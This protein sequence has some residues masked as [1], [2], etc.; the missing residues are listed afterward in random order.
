[1]LYGHSLGNIQMQYYAANNWDADLKAVVLLGMF[2][3]LPWKSRHML[4]ANEDTFRLLSDAAFKALREGRERELLPLRMGRTGTEA[5]PVTG[6]HFLSYRSESSST[7]DGTYWIKRIPRPILMVRDA[8]DAVVAPF[9]PYMLL[10][11]A[12][13]A[14]SLVPSIKYVML[15]NSKGTSFA[16][17]SFADNQLPLV[18]TITAWLA[19]QHL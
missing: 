15:P 4:I 5:E 12:T 14:G 2:A 18:D 3:N 7:A 1:V 13:S 16:A 17:H 8:S 11:A 6:Q 9:E 10:S 19:D